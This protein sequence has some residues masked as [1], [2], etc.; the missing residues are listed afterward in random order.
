MDDLYRDFIL[1]HYKRPRNFGELAAPR[2]RGARGQPA[3]RRRARRADRG[4]RRPHRRPALPGPRLRDLAGR[5]VD[6]L[7]GADRHGGRATPASSTR[8]GCSSCSGIPVS[9][10]RRKC[11]LLSLKVVRHALTG[12]GSWPTDC[13]GRGSARTARGTAHA[14]SHR[15]RIPT[16][17]L[18]FMATTTRI[19]HEPDRR[20]REGRAG[21]RARRLARG[22]PGALADQG[23]ARLDGRRCASSPSRSSSASRCRSGASTSPSSNFDELVLYSPPTTGRFDSW[24]DVPKEM[25]DT[26]EALGIPQAE[27]EHLAGVVGVWRQEPV[28]EGLKEEYAK[29]GILFCSMD[30]AVTRVPRPRPEVLHDASACR[31]RTT[32]SRRCTARSGRAARSS[33]SRRASS[34]TC[35]CRPTSAWRAPARA[36]SSTR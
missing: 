8:A 12:D 5:R 30:T 10:T 13:I 24:D 15:N 35:R 21:R 29:L 7:R 6:R 36:P 34:A 4:R 18:G 23:R 16:A 32:S 19:P 28:Y 22:H 20:E 26:Y 17:I 14:P 2:P 11:A 1:E 3:V 27:R 25:K 9:A 33:T 31:R